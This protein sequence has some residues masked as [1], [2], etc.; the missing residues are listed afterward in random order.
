MKRTGQ[1]QLSCKVS[2]YYISRTLQHFQIAKFNWVCM[3]C[4]PAIS[5]HANPV[6]ILEIHITTNSYIS[7]LQTSNLSFL[8]ISTWF[9]HL[10][11]IHKAPS[12]KGGQLGHM[13]HCC[14]KPTQRHSFSVVCLKEFTM[15]PY[16]I[17]QQRHIKYSTI[18]A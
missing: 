10:Y 18:V 17:L 14:K 13:T 3:A 16:S 7:M 5:F 4:H 2:V 1:N 15:G 9:F 6:Y 8:H 12:I 11:S